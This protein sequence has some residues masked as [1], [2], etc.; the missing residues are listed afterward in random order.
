MHFHHLHHLVLLF[1]FLLLTA[2]TSPLAIPQT[3]TALNTTLSTLLN[4]TPTALL[5]PTLCDPIGCFSPGYFSIIFDAYASGPSDDTPMGSLTLYGEAASGSTFSW[6]C[7]SG[8]RDL[9]S[10]LPWTFMVIAPIPTTF[11]AVFWRF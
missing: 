10:W 7:R 6:E 8:W 4:T 2:L 9:E 11:H 1:P 5:V 3:S